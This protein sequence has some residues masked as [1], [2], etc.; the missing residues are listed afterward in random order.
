[1][2]LAVIQTETLLC[3]KWGKGHFVKPW[4]NEVL[5]GWA[6]LLS[7][8]AL[9]TIVRFTPSLWNRIKRS[10]SNGTPVPSSIQ[11]QVPSPL[12]ARAAD[13]KAN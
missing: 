3:I 2:C 10:T 11:S 13:K 9:F 12:V 1:M 6:V 7:L 4:P 8:W 5:I